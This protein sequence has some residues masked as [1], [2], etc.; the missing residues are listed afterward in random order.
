MIINGATAGAKC[1][2][3]SGVLHFRAHYP[4]LTRISH[5]LLHCRAS[6]FTG[7]VS[8]QQLIPNL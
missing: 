2:P 4:N 6:C 8:L 7:S 3:Y 5:T 1:Q